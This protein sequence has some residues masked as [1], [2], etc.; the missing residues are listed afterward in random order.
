MKKVTY[1]FFVVGGKAYQP[2]DQL[3]QMFD[4]DPWMITPVDEDFISTLSGILHS[5]DGI[6]LWLD[7]LPE[8][9]LTAAGDEF[10]R[11]LCRA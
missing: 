10:R 7:I 8:G 9:S 4:V 6:A 3:T 1:E 2:N 11:W 5:A